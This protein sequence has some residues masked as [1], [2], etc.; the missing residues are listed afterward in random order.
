VEARYVEYSDSN[1]AEWAKGNPRLNVA[2]VGAE[3][4]MPASTSSCTRREARV[5]LTLA[6]ARTVEAL[7]RAAGKGSRRGPGSV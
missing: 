2:L 6:N 3:L 1:A 5:G 4:Q 7:R